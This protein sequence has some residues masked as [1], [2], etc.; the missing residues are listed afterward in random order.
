MPRPFHL[1]ERTQVQPP[2]RSMPKLPCS[3]GYSKQ[4]RPPVIDDL[5]ACL[6]RFEKKSTIGARLSPGSSVCFKKMVEPK[7]PF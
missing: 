7:L 6:Y 4:V 1:G 2:A 5:S 3:L